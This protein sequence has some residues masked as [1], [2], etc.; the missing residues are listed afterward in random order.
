MIS[1]FF[2]KVMSSLW[3]VWT[4]NRMQHICNTGAHKSPYLWAFL[5]LKT[6]IQAN[7]KKERQTPKTLC[8]RGFFI[9]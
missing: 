5:V 6:I 8:F 9:F 7:I 2:V 3:N 1:H 4:V